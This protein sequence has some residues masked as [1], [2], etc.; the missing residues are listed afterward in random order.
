[1]VFPSW[2]T[3]IRKGREARGW[4]QLELADRLKTSAPTVSNWE[5]GRTRP[6]IEQGNELVLA[7]GLGAEEFWTAMGVRFTPPVPGFLAHTIRDL[8]PDDLRVL[9]R[10]ARGLLELRRLEG[11]QFH[12][13]R[14]MAGAAG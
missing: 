5:T 1:M 4:S 10:S 8:P 3:L 7:L 12:E 6:T 2:S 14:Y 11:G 13:K 9:E